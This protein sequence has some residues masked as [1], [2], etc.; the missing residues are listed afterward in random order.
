LSSIGSEDIDPD[1]VVA[2]G[3][4]VERQ[5]RPDANLQDTAADTFGG[6]DRRAA[7]P[8]KD[9]TKHD[10]VDRC[11]STIDLRNLMSFQFSR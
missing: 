8:V 3:I 5:P 7:A 1:D 11:P 6:V 4:V 2:L 10:I 9:R